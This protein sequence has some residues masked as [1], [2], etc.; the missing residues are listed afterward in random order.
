MS[1][2]GR[3]RPNKSRLQGCRLRKLHANL[4]QIAR[5]RMT[6]DA[7]RLK[8][9]LPLASI[10]A[11][12]ASQCAVC[13]AVSSA[14]RSKFHLHLE[15]LGNAVNIFLA[16]A[17]KCR[18]SRLRTAILDQRSDLLVLLVM[19]DNDRPDQVRRLPAPRSLPV[20]ARTIRDI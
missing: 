19:Q 12:L 7:V 3:G 14:V 13:L 18:H 9:F 16:Q 1:G 17:G 15:E 10:A 11:S 5:S 4:C 2:P 20:T 6:S 8:K